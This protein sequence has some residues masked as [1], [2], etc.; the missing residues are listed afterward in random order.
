MLDPNHFKNLLNNPE[1]TVEEDLEKLEQ[2]L[3]E[4]PY[5]QSARALQLKIYKQ[6]NSD[7]YNDAL[8]KTA[9]H[10]TDRDV[11]FQFITSESFSDSEKEII[12]EDQK[13]FEKDTDK[14]NTTLEKSEASI[15]K[16]LGTSI[17]TEQIAEEKP[18]SK[19]E[20]SE[21][22]DDLDKDTAKEILE[23]NQPLSFNKEDTY[24]FSE[25][26]QLTSR[27]PIVRDSEEENDT[28]DTKEELKESIKD[29]KAPKTEKVLH[30][31]DTFLKNNPRPKQKLEFSKKVSDDLEIEVL[32]NKHDID[33][34]FKNVI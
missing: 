9:A 31:V 7:L 13:T 26:L 11:L 4:H 34:S 2:L 28:N 8:R 24:S 25:W 3:E 20:D 23:L 22:A 10:T 33:E 6:K 1:S 16:E 29:S 19:K 15:E 14:I 17:D 18:V 27:K 21:D 32:N 5:L 30:L 12:K